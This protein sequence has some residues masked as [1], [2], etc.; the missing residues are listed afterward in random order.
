MKNMRL[1]K[2]RKKRT[3]TLEQ[4]IKKAL[5]RLPQWRRKYIFETKEQEN[6]IIE[7]MLYSVKEAERQRTKVNIYKAFYQ[8]SSYGV[9]PKRE[10]T[11]RDIFKA[12]KEQD[13]MLYNKYNSYM[14]RAGYSAAN[15][16]YNVDNAQIDDQGYTTVVQLELPPGKDTSYT[17]LVIEY[18]WQDS[19]IINAEM[20]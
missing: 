17:T 11:L 7:K 12:F 1:S 4:R 13:N 6:L 19:E 9:R 10:G 15:Y 20:Y 16:F 18:N 5:Y 8:Q 3:L 2:K 14:Y